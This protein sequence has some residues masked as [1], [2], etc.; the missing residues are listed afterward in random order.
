MQQAILSEPFF[1]PYNDEGQL[2]ISQQIRWHNT[3]G[4]DGALSENPVA[5][6]L[7]RK[8]EKNKFRLF[9]STFLEYEFIKGLKFKTLFGGD[10]DY[11]FREEFR[12]S[13]I[14]NYRNDVSSVVPTAQERTRVRQNIISENTLTYAKEFKKHN[15]NALA[16][17][18]YQ[19]ENSTSTFVDA[20]TLDSNNI[21]NIAGTAVTTVDKDIS[22]WARISYFGRVQYDYDSK[23]LVS[24]SSRRDGSSRFGLNTKFG[25]FSSF[26]AGWIVSNENFFPENSILSKLK[27]RYSW[28]QTGNDQIGDFGSIATLRNL[29]GFLNGNLAVGQRPNT[30]HMFFSG[31]KQK[32]YTI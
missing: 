29:N 13:T 25:N 24:V 22:E 17:Y 14:G 30:A 11:S 4:T 3:G 5:T 12:P 28:G 15:L 26:S 19:K 21:E 23:Y 2:N 6:A 9:G 8:D 16:G 20:P 27:L 7:R 31:T 10:Y 32:V 1:T 18:S